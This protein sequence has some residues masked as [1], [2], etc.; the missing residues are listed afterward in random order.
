MGA[1]I[2]KILIKMKV[3]KYVF[4][5]STR[6][7]VDGRPGIGG[8]DFGGSLLVRFN[9]LGIYTGCFNILGVYIGYTYTGCISQVLNI[10]GIYIGYIY[11]V[12]TPG[13]MPQLVSRRRASAVADMC[14]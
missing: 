10:P 14:V 11:W 9:I 1:K 2:E 3:Q 5:L 13:I 8:G 12:Y 7:A 4:F 6:R